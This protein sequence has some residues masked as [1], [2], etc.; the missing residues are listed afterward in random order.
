MVDECVRVYCYIEI[1]IVKYKLQKMIFSSII[2]MDSIYIN[3]ILKGLYIGQELP[4]LT[5]VEIVGYEVCETGSPMA[6]G[7]G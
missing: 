1:E 3:D 6:L 4:E 2:K 5:L 7:N